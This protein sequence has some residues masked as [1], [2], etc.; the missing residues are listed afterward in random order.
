MQKLAKMF[1]MATCLRVGL[2]RG[3]P[4]LVAKQGVLSKVVA[5]L[6]AR[7]L[8]AVLAFSSWRLWDLTPTRASI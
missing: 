4:G 3:V 8:K 2:D 5:S 1:E 6:E 7:H